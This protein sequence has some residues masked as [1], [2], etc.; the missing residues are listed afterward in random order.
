MYIV[1]YDSAR[2][3]KIKYNNIIVDIILYYFMVV[4]GIIVKR[5]IVCT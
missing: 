5:K 3:I 4:F 2:Y 1:F